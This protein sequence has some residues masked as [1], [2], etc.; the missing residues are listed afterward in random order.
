MAEYEMPN[1]QVYF[2]GQDFELKSQCLVSLPE[3]QEGNAYMPSIGSCVFLYEVSVSASITHQGWM[4]PGFLDTNKNMQHNNSTLYTN[5]Y[6]NQPKDFA[7]Q[8]DPIRRAGPEKFQ[9]FPK[10]HFFVRAY[11]PNA[12]S[13]KPPPFFY[14]K[15]MHQPTNQSQ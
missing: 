8:N 11:R 7:V 15:I 1:L 6:S 14:R 5:L 2:G 13:F 4:K 9:T 3:A 12:V 10:H